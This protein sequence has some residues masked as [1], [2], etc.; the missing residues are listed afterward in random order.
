VYQSAFEQIC[1]IEYPVS[2]KFEK[3]KAPE[4]LIKKIYSLKNISPANFNLLIPSFEDSDC[5][6]HLNIG[7]MAEFLRFTE[8]GSNLQF[9]AID[10]ENKFIFDIELNEKN[11]YD[12][13]LFDLT[14]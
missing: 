9:T 1:K 6:V 12:I 7:D 2:A 5:Y 10:T 4:D 14:G 8:C 11:G 3:P 13:C